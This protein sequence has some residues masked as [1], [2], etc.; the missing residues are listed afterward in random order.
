MAIAVVVTANHYL[1]DVMAG[2][3]VLM[4]AIASVRA[5]DRRFGEESE[6]ENFSGSLPPEA[7]GA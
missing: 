5:Y 3:I 2:L 6:H 7:F 1:L 4:L